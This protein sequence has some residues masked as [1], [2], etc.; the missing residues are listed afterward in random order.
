M[1]KHRRR[2]S[3]RRN[4]KITEKPSLKKA[5]KSRSPVARFL[6]T[7][8][9]MLIGF[10]LIG[11]FWLYV[12]RLTPA[13]VPDREQ[14]V[15]LLSDY[16]KIR[17]FGSI[18]ELLGLL[19]ELNDWPKKAEVPIRIEYQQ[20]RIEIAD[21]IL[22]IESAQL[23]PADRDFAVRSKLDA[24]GA[25]YGL[26]LLQ[27]LN[28]PGVVQ[29]TDD[30]VQQ[31]V[32]DD[33]PEISKEAR[34]LRC[35]L[36]CFEF[37]KNPDSVDFDE[38]K[39]N[40]MQLN[41]DYANDPL[42]VSSMVV[43]VKR[44]IRTEDDRVP[45]LVDTLLERLGRSENPE[46]GTIASGLRDFQLF[47][48]SKI[49]KYFFGDWLG[50]EANQ[51]VLKQKMISLASNPETGETMLRRIQ[52]GMLWLERVKGYDIEREVAEAL[53]NSASARKVPQVAEQAEQI[54]RDAIQRIDSIGKP[55][56]FRETDIEGKPFDPASFENR[57]VAL[58]FWDPT[59]AASLDF[60]QRICKMAGR[61]KE[62]FPI[63]IIAVPTRPMERGTP[64]SPLKKLGW[65]WKQAR[66]PDERV[67]AYA[68]QD[69][70]PVPKTPYLILIGRDGTIADINPD[71]P[72]LLVSVT[73]LSD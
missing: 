23:S 69:Q 56:D 48:E 20:K 26:D 5:L 40:L 61:N 46:I 9:G 43:L 24:A 67:P 12:N 60:A 57:L 49:D 16:E 22:A 6:Q 35:K 19:S 68:Y 58:F 41:E 33:S 52:E 51:K 70:F 2:R 45:P 59:D 63:Q 4:N 62:Q 36:L 30:L 37:A 21:R 47:Y 72:R 11:G 54:G 55:W 29:Q 10:G 7:L 18:E 25:W 8:I 71:L 1:S 53:V 15:D 28:L 31:Y 34:M 39:S 27:E 14:P 38:L 65:R 73:Q 17:D 44:M 42:I 64:Q 13:E 66:F 3:K 32:D 50:T